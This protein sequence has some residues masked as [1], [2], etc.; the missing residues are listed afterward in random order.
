MV[1]FRKLIEYAENPDGDWGEGFMWALAL[2]MSEFVRVTLFLF[3]YALN[4]RTATRLKGALMALLYSK[5]LRTSNFESHG[6]G[7][8][9]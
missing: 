9:S 6:V 8:V 1:F 5:I 4:Y 3:C 2:G 7:E